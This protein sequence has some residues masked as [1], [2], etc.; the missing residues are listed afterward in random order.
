MR[1]LLGDDISNA[2]VDTDSYHNVVYNIDLEKMITDSDK[3]RKEAI[4]KYGKRSPQVLDRWFLCE[5]FDRS[6]F[7]KE[8]PCYDDS[9][10]KWFEKLKFEHADQQILGFISPMPKV[11]VDILEK[12]EDSKIAKGIPKKAKELQLKTEMYEECIFSAFKGT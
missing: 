9:Q 11:Y 2:S 12:W 1:D 8:H 3:E 6:S 4:S 7:P 5:D 10:N